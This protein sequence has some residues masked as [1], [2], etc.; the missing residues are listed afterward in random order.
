MRSLPSVI[1]VSLDG[2][3]NVRF[4]GLWSNCVLSKFCDFTVI[5][6]SKLRSCAYE[7]QSSFCQFLCVRLMILITAIIFRYNS[8]LLLLSFHVCQKNLPKLNRSLPRRLTL[9]KND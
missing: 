3:G 1:F 2:H 5:F 9:F 7:V 4:S 6:Q 8:Y